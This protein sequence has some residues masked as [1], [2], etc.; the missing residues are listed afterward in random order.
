MRPITFLS[1]LL[2]LLAGCPEPGLL[3]P[4]RSDM[5]S[6]DTAYDASTVEAATHDEDDLLMQLVVDGGA[7]DQSEPVDLASPPDLWNPLPQMGIVAHWSFDDASRAK[8]DGPNHN[9]GI[10]QGNLKVIPGRVGSALQFDG[11]S[12]ITVPNSASLDLVG[13]TAVT[14][15][16]WV[17]LDL[18]AINGGHAVMMKAGEYGHVLGCFSDMSPMETYEATF[19]AN[20]NG[21]SSFW[22]Q[23][24]FAGSWHLLVS[25]WDGKQV[26]Q[27]LDS[28]AGMP[29]ILI[30][31]GIVDTVP[32]SGLGIGCHDVSSDGKVV[33]YPAFFHGA[34]DE[35]VIYNR[36]LGAREI[37]EY[38]VATK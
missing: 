35:V 8:D 14:I 36:A 22:G 6:I 24:V 26:V 17:R 23:Q 28:Q 10:I 5:R 7:N 1:L 18:C 19:H 20:K 38:Y 27:Y 3:A 31:A 34:I 15:M 37:A 12:C 4:T 9:D 25:V 2:L 16:A 21:N 33:I 11:L 29:Q 30:G 32:N 13:A